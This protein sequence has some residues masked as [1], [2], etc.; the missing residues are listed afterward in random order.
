MM[1]IILA[2]FIDKYILYSLVVDKL[3]LWNVIEEKT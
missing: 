1:F 3:Q 2:Y